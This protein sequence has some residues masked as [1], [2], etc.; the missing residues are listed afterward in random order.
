MTNSSVWYRY[1]VI[2][3]SELICS[4]VQASMLKIGAL[5]VVSVPRSWRRRLARLVVAG[6]VLAGSCI[7]CRVSRRVAGSRS[8]SGFV[9]VG[10][11]VGCRITGACGYAIAWVVVV[12]VVG[13]RVTGAGWVGGG[14]GWFAGAA[15]GDP[16][17][18]SGGSLEGGGCSVGVVDAGGP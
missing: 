13:S 9:V 8:G 11:R 10:F 12:M 5:G 2:D 15:G 6:S 4:L 17:G 18:A 16:L 1:H 3:S 7:G 14:G